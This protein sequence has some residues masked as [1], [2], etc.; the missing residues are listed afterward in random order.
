MARSQLTKSLLEKVCK[1][2]KINIRCYGSVIAWI[3]DKYTKVYIILANKEV[4]GGTRYFYDRRTI[5]LSVNA[6]MKRY[7]KPD[8]DIHEPQEWQYTTEDWENIHDLNA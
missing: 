7:Q 4:V 5:T 1:A 6:I 8:A 2:K 3:N